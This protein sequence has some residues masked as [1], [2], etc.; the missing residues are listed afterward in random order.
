MFLTSLLIIPGL[1]NQPV[2][3][4]LEMGRMVRTGETGGSD[5]NR[6]SCPTGVRPERFATPPAIQHEIQIKPIKSYAKL[7]KQFTTNN[8][9]AEVIVGHAFW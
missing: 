3:Q 6:L 9:V 8:S 5:A 7:S 1:R 2:S 4:A